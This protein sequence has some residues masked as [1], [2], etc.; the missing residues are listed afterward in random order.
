MYI[1]KHFKSSKKTGN[2]VAIYHTTNFH[3]YNTTDYPKDNLY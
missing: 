3:K 1:F 2:L